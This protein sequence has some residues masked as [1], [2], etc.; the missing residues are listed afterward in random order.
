MKLSYSAEYEAFRDE[1]RRFLAEEWSR[2]KAT[3]RE[4]GAEFV[5]SF[6]AKATGK[7]YL[8]RGIPCRFG[9]SEQPADVI[10]AQIISEAFAEAGA[11]GEV[12]GIGMMMLVPTLL[13]VGSEEQKEMFVAKTVAG[14]YKWAQGYSEPGSGS[15]LASLRST[16]VVDGDEWVINGHKIWTTRAQ[17][18]NYMFALLR[19]EP[20]AP[21]HA[22]LSYIL[23][24]F[25]QPGVTVRPIRQING[26]Q[27]FCEVFLD[28]VRTPLSW[29]V[30]KRGEGWAVSKV[31]LKHE[32]NAVGSSGRSGPVF[33]SLIRLAKEV[34]IDGQ[35]AIKH[36]A[37]RGKLVEVEG[38]LK[39]QLYSGYYQLTLNARGETAPLLGMTNKLTTTNALQAM[40]DIATEIL[41]AAGLRAPGRQAGKRPGIERWNN[42]ILGSLG[43]SIAG[44]TSNIQRNIISERGLGLPRQEAQ[45]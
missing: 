6:R 4:S 26:D 39:S 30:G 11:A 13:E 36:P 2:E 20:D 43:L 32:R 12:P 15:D 34:E 19:T 42:Q 18:A 33:R 28:N 16:A 7:G 38:Y 1:V 8:Y 29:T 40:A 37:I 14:D 17:D 22:G 9:G 21:K 23:L 10:K 31:N 45:D 24:D 3:Q 35:P 27:E 41:D 5:R 25:K 44:G